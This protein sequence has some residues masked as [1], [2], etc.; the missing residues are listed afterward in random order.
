[1]KRLHHGVLNPVLPE[2]PGVILTLPTEVAVIK[3]QK[4]TDSTKRDKSHWEHVSIAHRKIQKSSGSVSG[5]G[6]GSGSLPSSSSGLGSRRRGR[7]PRASKER[8]R[9]QDRGRSNLS[10]AKHASPCS[11]FPYTNA[12][13]A[14]IYHFISNWKNV[15]GD[16]ICGYQVVADFVFGDEHQ[17]LENTEGASIPIACRGVRRVHT[18][19]GRSLND[20]C[21]IPPLH[22]QWIHHRSEWVS[23][24]ADSYQH[25]IA[26]WNAR[27]ARNK[28]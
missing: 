5:S 25:R 20:M 10:A 15:I 28:K 13:P 11:I 4:K 8:G 24:W 1:M 2:D 6:T 16:R 12:F 7:P 21:P 17:W 3:G 9:G 23:N 19:R 14:F 27:V 26:D 22:V 18:S